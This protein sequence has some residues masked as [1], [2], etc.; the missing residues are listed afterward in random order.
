MK[1][2]TIITISFNEENTIENTITSVLNQNETLFEY[3]IIDGNSE[4][5]TVEIINKFRDKITEIVSEKDKGIYDAMNKG[6]EY[7][8]GK[9]IIFMN[10]GDTFYNYRVL[11]DLSAAVDLGSSDFIYGN[12]IEFDKE[13]DEEYVR[14]SRNYKYVWYGM[15]A[16]HQS[17]FYKTEIIRRNNLRYNLNYKIASDYDFTFR[18]IKYCQGITPTSMIIS[19]FLKGGLS[20]NNYFKGNY[21]QWKIKRKEGNYNFMKLLFIFLLKILMFIVQKLLPFV[22]N[23]TVIKEMKR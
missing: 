22:Y 1:Q 5:K 6:I 11:E 20:Q 15:F 18:Y 13:S 21:E 9:F 4:D 8:N 7:A 23:R 3:I 2:F 12:A 16:H 14:Y 17:M 19:R 10:A